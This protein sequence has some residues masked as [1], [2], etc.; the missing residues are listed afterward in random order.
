[1]RSRG[2]STGWGRRETEAQ[3]EAGSSHMVP[4]E[5]PTEPGLPPYPWA[6]Q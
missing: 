5:A 2:G 4:K 3:R 6:L 1:M